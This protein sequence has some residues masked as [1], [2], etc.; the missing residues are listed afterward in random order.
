MAEIQASLLADVLANPD[1]DTPRLVMADWFEGNG[2]PERAQLIRV[3][4]ELARL[5]RRTVRSLGCDAWVYD[6][7]EAGP[8]SLQERELLQAH[9]GAWRETLPQVQGLIWGEFERGFVRALSIDPEKADANWVRRLPDWLAAAPVQVL[10]LDRGVTPAHLQEVARLPC[11]KQVCGLYLSGAFG[12]GPRPGVEGARYLADS[13]F[14]T[15]LTGLGFW[16]ADI[17]SEG[18]AAI[19]KSSVSEKLTYLYLAYDHVGMDGAKAASDSPRLRNLH[20]LAL[21]ETGFEPGALRLMLESPLVTQ[22]HTLSLYWVYGQLEVA[23]ALN[24]SYV[25]NLR[26]VILDGNSFR[27]E[28]I[29]ILAAASALSALTDL[30]IGKNEVTDT[31]ARALAETS[32]L[33]NLRTLLLMDNEI[34]DE[35]VVALAN[36][37][38]LSNLVELNLG[39]N[40]VGDAGAVALAQSPYVTELRELG[41][42]TNQIG[43]AGA[44]ALVRSSRLHQLRSLTIFNNDAIDP[45]TNAELQSRWGT[46]L[47]SCG[48]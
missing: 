28:G 23:Q 29:R 32:C 5:P 18:L 20:N 47:G 44:R 27:D 16:S 34:G 33:R 4:C 24:S 1:D 6:R 39:C 45:D 35:G 22:L 36:S 48:I 3:Q 43:T 31:G 17:G 30:C 12:D 13:P 21:D 41:L 14:L 2:Q 25:R 7:E 42:Y 19:A 11:L 15:N 37:S 9:E 10:S 8:L 40:V 46:G 38:A 26:R